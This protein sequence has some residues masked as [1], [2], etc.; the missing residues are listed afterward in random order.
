MVHAKYMTKR[1][2]RIGIVLGVIAILVWASGGVMNIF[3][4]PTAYA[5]GDLTVDWGVPPGTPLFNIANAAP[6]QSENRN[7]NVT[8]SS[9]DLKPIAVR[10]LLTSETASLSGVLEIT[11]TQG[12]TTVYG[13]KT[14][15]QFF[16]ES[17]GPDGMALG[18]LNSGATKQYTFKLDFDPNA[19]NE[20]QNTK[21]VFDLQIGV[22]FSLPAACGDISQ[23]TS[24]IMG[25][26]GNDKL[27]GTNK[28]DLI[29]GLEGN[30]TID[31]GN[32]DD[33]IVGGMGNNKLD[34][35]NG[36]DVITAESGNDTIDG[37]NEDDN[38]SAG[39]GNNNIIGGNGNDLIV[40]GSGVDTIDVGNDRD[41][42]HAGG[43]NDIIDGGNGDDKLFGETGTDKANGGNGKDTCEAETRIK[44]EL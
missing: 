36:K 27:N 32:N 4:S 1:F 5:V 24:T 2:I 41:E 40:S 7:V 20:F 34:G 16:S 42:V 43:G 39:D 9:P 18:N 31:G 22:A 6:G 44:C 12:A 8:N 29:I 13:P 28:K 14:L 25:T 23:Y 10:G 3:K 17:N 37:G 38:I 19:G 26:S 35:G 33:C 21:I 30:D 11:I 15:S